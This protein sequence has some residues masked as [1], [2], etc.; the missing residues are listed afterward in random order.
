MEIIKDLKPVIR[1]YKFTHWNCCEFTAIED[2][3]KWVAGQYN[4]TTASVIC[5]KCGE[6]FYDDP[7]LIGYKK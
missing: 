3:F 6:Q 4:E 5:P 1:K 7:K 2:E